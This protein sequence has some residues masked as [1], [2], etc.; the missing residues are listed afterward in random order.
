MAQPRTERDSIQ[1]LIEILGPT[2]VYSWQ[3]APNTEP[4]L[5]T[6]ALVSPSDTEIPDVG[7][8]GVLVYAG[9]PGELQRQFT[10]EQLLHNGFSTVV[11]KI[12][13]QS[14]NGSPVWRAVSWV[15]LRRES[16]LGRAYVSI[17]SM[18]NQEDEHN[19]GSVS[20][21]GRL[22]AIANGLARLMGG[23]VAIE[24]VERHV[25]AYSSVEGQPIDPLRQAGILAR[26][27]PES[28]IHDGQYQELYQ[29]EAP[30][31]YPCLVEGEEFPRFAI[32]IRDGEEVLGS[33]WVLDTGQS[34]PGDTAAALRRAAA[35]SREALLNVR[36]KE[37]LLLRLEGQ[38]LHRLL[39]GES[40]N[41]ME[42]A[43]HL[44]QI[45]STPTLF[46]YAVPADDNE[47]LR[48]N[49]L[50]LAISRKLGTLGF[51]AV[52]TVIARDL[53]VMI[54]NCRTK[55]AMERCANAIAEAVEERTTLP[56]RVVY[57]R[58]GLSELRSGGAWA[59]LCLGA[60]AMTLPQIGGQVRDINSLRTYFFLLDLGDQALEAA[61]RYSPAASREL[62]DGDSPSVADDRK[63]LLAYF[64]HF[65]D[66]G[67]AS[68]ALHIHPNTLRYRLNRAKER[69]E[70]DLRGGAETLGLWLSLWAKELSD[71]TPDKLDNLT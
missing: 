68:E 44:E 20:P 36:E 47:P 25:I 5:L 21:S 7:T 2:T 64:N 30:R 3:R 31:R 27:V 57:G 66:I 24:N 50:T 4:R 22:F 41:P 55:E 45:P 54:T 17:W 63:S 40:R 28:S 13:G 38:R 18:L 51:Q 61:R 14:T 19:V 42:F 59:E 49:E 9:S 48:V 35:D 8:G 34:S 1:A 60:Q 58:Y 23:A 32:T 16:S 37:L 69:W 71:A 53:A 70:L 52:V 15:Y 12:D 29:N 62:L 10:E 33:I 67:R 43:Q 11:V 46:H 6:S 56:T 65:G 26:K 39:I